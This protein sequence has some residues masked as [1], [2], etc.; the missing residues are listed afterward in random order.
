[1]P[2]IT[3]PKPLLGLD[4]IEAEAIAKQKV[5]SAEQIIMK[6]RETEV[7]LSQ[8]KSVKEACQTLEISGQTYFRWRK[9]YGGLNPIQ[10]KKL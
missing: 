3:G 9:E 5:I 10:T 2:S 8:K 7:L 4:P 6:L 1:M